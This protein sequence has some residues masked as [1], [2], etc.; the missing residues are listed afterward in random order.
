[1]GGRGGGGGAERGVDCEDYKRGGSVKTYA[2][3]I[4]H[5]ISPLIPLRTDSHRGFMEHLC[6]FMH[7]HSTFPRA[8]RSEIWHV[9]SITFNLL[10][11]EIK[12]DCF[13]SSLPWFQDGGIEFNPGCPPIASVPTHGTCNCCA[14]T[15]WHT[16][17]TGSTRTSGQGTR[18]CRNLPCPD[19]APT[20]GK[21]FLHGHLGG[22]GTPDSVSE[23]IRAHRNWKMT[24][25]QGGGTVK[26]TDL[27]N[28]IPISS[29]VVIRKSTAAAGPLPAKTVFGLGAGQLV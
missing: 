24:N 4:S 21:F 15:S 18:N 5:Q 28:H 8:I 12:L 14:M 29:L 3:V 16:I 20:V 17:L 6:N 11:E 7:I 23:G 2:N 10:Q 26:I 25:L 22:S 27:S 13:V 19:S 1:M 9:Q